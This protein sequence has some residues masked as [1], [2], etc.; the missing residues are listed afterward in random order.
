MLAGFFAVVGHSWD[1]DQKRYGARLVL[2]NQ[3]E[4]GTALQEI[5][6][7]Q[8]SDRIWSPNFS[9]IQCLCERGELD[10]KEHDKKV[11]PIHR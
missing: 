2:I 5:M 3:T 9:S 8:L 7:L 11:Y 1:L 6:V 10:N 4:S